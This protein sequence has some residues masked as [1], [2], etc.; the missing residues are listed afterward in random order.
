MGERARIT[1]TRIGSCFDEFF[2]FHA[3]GEGKDGPLFLRFVLPK[4][5]PRY[6]LDRIDLDN[7]S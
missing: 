5:F 4:V 1:T 2:A 6:P 3:Q 7:H